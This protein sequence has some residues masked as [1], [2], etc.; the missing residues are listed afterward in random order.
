VVEHIDIGEILM[1]KYLEY[2]DEKSSK[3]WQIKV[4]GGAH[5]VRY[6]KIGSEG[7]SQVKTFATGEEALKDAEKLVASKLKKGYKEIPPEERE[8]GYPS[9]SGIDDQDELKK[10]LVKHF[11][12]LADTPG[13]EPVLNAV[14]E[15]AHGVS[16]DEGN[17]IV[18]FRG[19]RVLTASPPADPVK[20]KDWP[21]SFQK[22]V[23]VHE[24]L[25]FPDQGW[26]LHLGDAGLFDSTFLQEVESE[27]LD[28]VDADDVLCPVTDYSDW[29]LYHPG[30]MNPWNEPGIAFF[31]HEGGD[32]EK[33]VFLNAGSLFLK[34]MAETLE[35]ACEVPEPGRETVDINE[36]KKWWN[37]LEKD[38]QSA[39]IKASNIESGEPSAGDLEAILFS[40]SF[41][42]HNRDL[43]LKT[44]EPLGMLKDL[45]KINI[46]QQIEISDI[47]P[48]GGLTGL[49][50]VSIKNMEVS[51][52]SPLEQLTH[53]LQ[54]ELNDMPVKDLSPLKNLL[55]LKD[56]NISKTSVSD[57]SPLKDLSKLEKIDFSD[58]KVESLETLTGHK[59]L[60][61]INCSNTPVTDLGPLKSFK[62]LDSVKFSQTKIG[63]L[64][65]L[66]ETEEIHS[67]FC[68]ETEV[69]FEQLLR[70]TSSRLHEYEDE[71][72]GCN[73]YS[74]YFTDIEIFTDAIEKID[75]SLEGIGSA[76]TFWVNGVLI[77]AI[78]RDK[79]D[80]GTRMLKGYMKQLPIEQ[81]EYQEDLYS[82]SIVL[83]MQSD[84]DSFAEEVLEK[85]K[86][87][88]M[89]KSGTVYNLA[90]YAAFKNDKEKLLEHM[91]C[92]LEMGYEPHRFREDEDFKSFWNDSDFIK[93][94][95]ETKGTDPENDPLGWWN[96]LNG[97]WQELFSWSV[98]D[99]E[100]AEDVREIFEIEGLDF[101]E[102]STLEPLRY[103]TDLKQIKSSY[104]MFTSIDPLE[105]LLKLENLEINGIEGLKESQ[106][107]SIDPLRKLVNLKKLRI[108]EENISDIGPLAG[109]LNLEHLT[110]IK[111]PV[112]SL[113]TLSGL[114]KLKS[115]WAGD[116]AIDDLKPLTRCTE[117]E[118]LDL[119]GSRIADIEPLQHMKKLKK[120]D[121]SR[122]Q[123]SDLE[124]LKECTLLEKLEC[125]NC[126]VTD[127]SPLENLPNLHHLALGETE[128]PREIVEE[129]RKVHPKCEVE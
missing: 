22:C 54:L 118:E 107:K 70:F 105:G 23:S 64:S 49:S 31:S 68:Q 110:L 128:I 129:F 82:H 127:L 43:N 94:Y 52:I 15:E 56:L 90:C 88:E 99:V 41:Y 66:Y 112:T 28:S 97:K 1:K 17:L 92:A 13:F 9:L 7:K 18:S 104:S 101:M 14:F 103:L 80:L 65:P 120:L 100:T 86:P 3:F 59:K 10:A 8:K 48:L 37:G 16:E 93:L 121:I 19:E 84:D 45:E 6:G 63:D 116:I 124:P 77:A 36:A 125:D 71:L 35:L 61:S 102:M 87:E 55:K 58:T 27:L 29:W 123:V 33:P 4:I 57:L 119:G 38:W 44:L 75:F 46:S 109:L 115:L 25:S 53:L 12:Y 26:A 50:S 51:D 98:G 85:L 113:D 79:I 34:L 24:N 72:S 81:R 78:K 117:I 60:R 76:L 73:I 67:L 39:F 32:I 83:L 47:S 74:D 114:T 2:R 89:T 40:T 20:Y 5:Q 108:V 69:S 96:S 62:K 42:S 11:S 95:T 91:K 106:I 111:I 122:T 21:Q 126:P 30:V